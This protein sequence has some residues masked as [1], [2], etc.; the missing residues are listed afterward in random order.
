MRAGAAG[1]RPTLDTL[2]EAIRPELVKHF[3]P[4]L[5]ARLVV[6]PYLQLGDP[7]IRTIVKLKLGKIQ[8]RFQEN[9]SAELTFDDELVATIASRCT[10]VDSGA[11]FG[12]STFNQPDADGQ[13]AL[14][15]F[16]SLSVGVRV[17]LSDPKRP[18]R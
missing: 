17:M 7:E 6:V 3:K 16:P 1:N 9:H 12:Q 4:A 18:E 15:G 8:R 14:Y 2:V 13:G 5:L 11:P 10:E